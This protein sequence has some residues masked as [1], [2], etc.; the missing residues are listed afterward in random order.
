[1]AIF[2]KFEFPKLSSKCHCCLLR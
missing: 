2:G 1:M